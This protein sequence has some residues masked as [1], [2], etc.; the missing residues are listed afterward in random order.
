MLSRSTLTNIL[1]ALFLSGAA[2]AGPEPFLWYD[3]DEAAPNTVAHDSSG[4]EYHGLVDTD[5]AEPNWDP[6]N[7]SVDGCLV[8]NNDTAVIVP[9]DVLADVNDAITIKIWLTD[10]FGHDG[11]NWL[12]DTGTGDYRMQAAIITE[13]N[14]QIF[15]RAGNDT[16]DVLIWDLSDVDPCLLQYGPPPYFVKDETAGTM[17]IGWK[18]LIFSRRNCDFVTKTGVNNTLANVKNNAFKI[19][20]LTEHDHDLVG[21]MH[22]FA[23]YDY[24]SR[25]TCPPPP[26]CAWLPSPRDGSVDVPVDV[27]LEWIPGDNILSHDVYLGTDSNA[28][29][30]ANTSSSEYKGNYSVNKYHTSGLELNRTY[31]WRVDE[32]N[33]PNVWKCYVWE[34][35]TADFLIVDDMQSYNDILGSGNQ[36]FD[37]W[38]DGFNNWTGAQIALGAAPLHPVH[39]DSQSMEFC[40]HNYFSF[41]NYAEIDANT[42]GPWPGNLKIGKD[43]TAFCVKALTL[44]FYGDPNN[45]ANEQMYV[46]L[47]NSSRHVA[48]VKYGDHGED[49]NDIRIEEWHEWN[50]DL[51]DFNDAGVSPADVNKVRIGF[52]DR[53]N[54]RPGGSGI[55]YLDDIRLYRPRCVAQYGPVADLSGDCVVDHKDL[56][57]IAEHWLDDEG[58]TADLYDDD[59]VNST[60]YAILAGMWLEAALWPAQ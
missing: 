19:G 44:F 47:E 38:D 50:I 15:W 58:T 37:T 33:E 32:V 46:A 25:F 23:M 13:P 30:D 14:L 43:W 2:K 10:A 56:K 12:F 39:G 24:A 29:S 27:V 53:D 59:M 26:E 35:T 31:Y 16:N 52:G 40:Y 20:A 48:V 4:N 5:L 17:T 1:I 3:F 60:D 18:S 36:I 57:V 8:F 51:Q 34:F 45:D 11:Y 28:V 22:L 42:T 9:N 49:M 21:R 41:C 6:A 7:G 55:V 54:P